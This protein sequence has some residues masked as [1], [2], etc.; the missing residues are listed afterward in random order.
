MTTSFYRVLDD[1]L[2]VGFTA[3]QDTA[4]VWCNIT[5]DTLR[6]CV[7]DVGRRCR[8]E[9]SPRGREVVVVQCFVDAPDDLAETYR[10]DWC[11]KCRA[12]VPPIPP[13]ADESPF[14]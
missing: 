12:V 2:T 7:D 8:C 14:G 11:E 10:L 5:S 3:H 6:E 4:D 9:T 1:R 13:W